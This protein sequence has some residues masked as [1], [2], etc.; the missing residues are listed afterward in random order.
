MTT[1]D[2]N[3]RLSFLNL[4][5]SLS[6]LKN[7]QIFNKFLPKSTSGQKKLKI[8]RQIFTTLSRKMRRSRLLDNQSQNKFNDEPPLSPAVRSSQIF[9]RN[10]SLASL[11]IN[12]TSILAEPVEKSFA[13]IEKKERL[14]LKF[15]E[16]EKS[17]KTEKNFREEKVERTEKSVFLKKNKKSSSIQ[18][19]GQQKRPKL[20]TKTLFQDRAYVKDINSPQTAR[21]EKREKPEVCFKTNSVKSLVSPLLNFKK[22]T[23][24]S[25]LNKE[26][27]THTDRIE[28]K[29]NVDDL[30]I[31]GWYT[32]DLI[33]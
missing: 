9:L 1:F 18:S 2:K 7:H 14:C 6:L 11:R 28:L 23:I 24:K 21:V 13:K 5:P 22:I 3:L 26:L 17:G 31:S 10:F 20:T 4:D 8:D 15:Q 27:V 25:K 30:D 29:V 19:F 32:N 12:G 16:T 33:S